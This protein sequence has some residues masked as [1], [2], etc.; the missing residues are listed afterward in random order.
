MKS[1]IHEI[2]ESYVSTHKPVRR[3]LKENYVSLNEEQ[4]FGLLSENVLVYL[5]EQL[6]NAFGFGLGDL[7]EEQLN[8]IFSNLLEYQGPV[9]R[10]LQMATQVDHLGNTVQTRSVP[11]DTP[12]L[13]MPN[14]QAAEKR[15]KDL[16]KVQ[17]IVG[18]PSIKLRDSSLKRMNRTFSRVLRAK[19]QDNTIIRGS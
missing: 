17:R 9:A 12:G 14:I 4:R 2:S 3:D 16:E 10:S 19:E 5:D 1:W 7:T 6:Q 15:K 13:P 8:T 18:D 11:S